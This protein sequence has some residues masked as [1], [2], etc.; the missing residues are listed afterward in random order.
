MF[1]TFS[2]TDKHIRLQNAKYSRYARYSTK[3]CEKLQNMR[4]LR[5]LRLQC[6]SLYTKSMTFTYSTVFIRIECWFIPFR[7]VYLLFEIVSL[8]FSLWYNEYPQNSSYSSI[9]IKSQLFYDHK[10]T[11]VTC[12]FSTR[13]VLLSV[14]S[15]LVF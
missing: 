2:K 8:S 10:R 11:Y 13:M 7:V 6:I 1:P 9:G 12:I 5:A 4:E 14:D 3:I 15:L